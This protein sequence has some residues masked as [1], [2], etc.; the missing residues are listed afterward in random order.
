MVGGSS[1]R[2]RAVG[3]GWLPLAL[4]LVVAPRPAVAQQVVQGRVAD[5]DTGRPL[6]RVA[7]SVMGEGARTTT[8]SIGGFR[9]DV[10]GDAPG[11]ALSFVHAGYTPL[12][13]SWVLPL[14][15]PIV[16]GLSREVPPARSATRITPDL[17]RRMDARLERLVGL[18]TGRLD[19]DDLADRER[20]QRPLLQALAPLLAEMDVNCEAC[21]AVGG[22]LGPDSS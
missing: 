9:L 7:V 3:T 14:D 20:P 10:A 2:R 8:D 6:A 21:A 11:I 17:L 16:V 12:R 1:V 22:R 4:V 15:A 18:K 5:A 19:P 13:R